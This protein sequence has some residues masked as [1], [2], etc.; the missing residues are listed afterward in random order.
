MNVA[1]KMSKKSDYSKNHWQHFAEEHKGILDMH[2]YATHLFKQDGLRN[3]INKWRP[4]GDSEPSE[5]EPDE[6]GMPT[7]SVNL[8]MSG[9]G[10]SGGRASRRELPLVDLWE[11]EYD[12]SRLD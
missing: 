7:D 9:R 10:S 11:E 5:S 2:A 8:R 6:D 1:A 4:R 3:K 12:L